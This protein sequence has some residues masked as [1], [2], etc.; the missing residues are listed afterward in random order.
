MR[1]QPIRYRQIREILDW[2][3]AFHERLSIEY[4]IMSQGQVRERVAL[5]L[6]YLAD[7]QRQLQNAIKHYEE[8]A[9]EEFLNTWHDHFP[10]LDLPETLDDLKHHL[11]VINT[12]DVIRLAVKFHDVLI[13]LFEEIGNTAPTDE[14]RDV[15]NDLAQMER[16]EKER[17]VRDSAFLEDF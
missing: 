14:V 11:S 10:E 16:R 7:H 2:M 3:Q 8:D 6:Q 9:S 13:C 4:H 17:M 5:L 12:D 15:F 1:Y